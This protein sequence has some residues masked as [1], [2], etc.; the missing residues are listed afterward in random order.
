MDYSTTHAQRMQPRDLILSKSSRQLESSFSISTKTR[1]RLLLTS[2]LQGH[3]L[4]TPSARAKVA[5]TG[6]QAVD[7]QL[8][9]STTH[10]KRL[11]LLPL[12]PEL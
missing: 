8:L 7:A 1:K 3:D 12:H 10:G 11:D 4:K 9:G 2:N 6:Q 5:G